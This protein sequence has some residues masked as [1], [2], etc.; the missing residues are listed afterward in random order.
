MSG[1]LIVT[2]TYTVCDTSEDIE[3]LTELFG[4]Q[5]WQQITDGTAAED[6]TQAL[7]KFLLLVYADIKKFKFHYRFA[8][9]VICFPP[10]SFL[11]NNSPKVLS[12]VWSEDMVN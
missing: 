2:N 5:I 7:S 3:L 6:P 9:P 12:D 11:A 8:F 1:Q 10:K 4:S